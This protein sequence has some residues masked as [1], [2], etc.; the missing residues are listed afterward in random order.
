M[1]NIRVVKYNEDMFKIPSGT[2]R[3]KKS[4]G[5]K[6]PIKLKSPP[7]NKTIKNK[8]LDE[9]RKNQQKQYK[10]LTEDN[11][12]ADVTSGNNA[13]DGFE[14][15]FAQSVEY[16]KTFAD[17]HR[18]ESRHNKT[19]REVK[20]DKLGDNLFSDQVVYAKTEFQ[21]PTYGCLKNGSLPTYRSYHNTTVRNTGSLGMPSMVGGTPINVSSPLTIGESLVTGSSLTVGGTPLNASS[22]SMVG[23]TPLTSS[24]PSMVGGMPSMVGGT[25]LNASSPSMVGGMPLNAS[26][27][28]TVGGTPLTSTSS[29]IGGKPLVTDRIK[30]PAEILLNEKIKQKTAEEEEVG[31]KKIKRHKKKI[32]RRTYRTGKDKYRPQIGVLLPNKT[33]RSNVTTKSYLL[34]Q[35]P[36]EEIRK[37]LIKQG[38]IKVGT[39]APND[40]LRKI[41]E[42]VQLIGGDIKNHNPDNLLYNFFNSKPS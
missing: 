26:S 38:F 35:T 19:I 36:I 30:S 12:A 5:S 13:V 33:I 6:P 40:V 16:M 9:I 34:K 39:S 27:P 1:S 32:L 37:T 7:K 29:L 8:I 28:L 2:Q 3:R 24:S 4:G 25:P 11:S 31:K 15:D 20:Q 18:E 23:G 14:N 21:K 22:P 42:S 10:S 17:K 41:Y